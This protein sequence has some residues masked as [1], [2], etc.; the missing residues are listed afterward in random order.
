MA[1]LKSVFSKKKNNNQEND[2]DEELQEEKQD[3]IQGIEDLPETSVKEVMI[4]RIDVDFINIHVSEQ[5]LYEKIAESGHSRFPVYSDSIDNVIG[6]LYVKDLI[7]V[8]AK[9]EPV[10]LEKIVRK[11]FF[12]PESKRIDSLLREFKR[13]HVHIAI[14]ID[15]YGGISGIVCL[16]EGETFWDLISAPA[17]TVSFTVPLLPEEADADSVLIYA[18]DPWHGY[19]KKEITDAAAIRDVLALLRTGSYSTRCA[20]DPGIGAWR[21]TV[22]LRR[23]SEVRHTVPIVISSQPG[24]IFVQEPS[25]EYFPGAW[26]QT[27]SFWDA[28]PSP[29]EEIS[30][31]AWAA[32]HTFG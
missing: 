24:V 28:V 29:A 22:V 19:R 2:I 14:A 13:R 10:D 3:M 21:L 6:V 12:V 20:A 25:G 15:E 16:E 31:E 27:G 4:P 30:R 7:K 32:V 1:F 9:K 11:A 26:D 18:N 17:E 8:I 23:G 5:E